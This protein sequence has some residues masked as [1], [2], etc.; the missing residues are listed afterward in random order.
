MFP[1]YYLVGIICA[2]IGIVC[3]AYL[4]GAGVMRTPAATLS[5]LL[6]AGCG[7]ADVW[8]RQ[9]VVPRM[10][11]IREQVAAAKMAGQELAP[12]LE[13]DWKA[14]HRLSVQ[15]NG[16]VLLCGLV[17]LFAFVYAKVV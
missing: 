15:V 4:L 14:M 10:V 12:E 2:A 3:V 8:M 11:E 6:L 1:R 9:G 5:L 13:A 16:V 17:L 7:A